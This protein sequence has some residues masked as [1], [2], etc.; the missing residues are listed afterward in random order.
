VQGRISFGKT[1][2]GGKITVL[3]VAR[4]GDIKLTDPDPSPY[5]E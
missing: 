4:R 2:D 3:T 1:G 5:I